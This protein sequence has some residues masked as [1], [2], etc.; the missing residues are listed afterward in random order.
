MISAL[1][2]GSAGTYELSFSIMMSCSGAPCNDGED[3]VKIIINEE[4]PDP[5]VYTVDYTNI[6]IQLQWVNKKF[7]FTVN[8]PVIDVRKDFVN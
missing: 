8:N 6:G 3:S 2:L 7:Q 5:I 1:D 4:T